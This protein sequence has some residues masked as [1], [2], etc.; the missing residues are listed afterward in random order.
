MPDSCAPCPPAPPHSHIACTCAGPSTR[1]GPSGSSRG[2]RT[3]VAA[4]VRGTS[5][6]AL[7]ALF[8]RSLC[9][10]GIG[11]PQRQQQQQH[12]VGSCQIFD[13]QVFVAWMPSRAAVVAIL[14]RLVAR[15]V[16][17]RIGRCG[18]LV[19]PLMTGNRIE[20]MGG[21]NCSDAA[22]SA[23]RRLV[24][25]EK[26]EIGYCRSVRGV[27]CRYSTVYPKICIIGVHKGSC[28]QERVR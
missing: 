23:E 15:F 18:G 22:S 26:G 21:K 12:K 6:L 14:S 25:E 13:W 4:G 9:T 8:K 24:E 27:N 20:K 28:E 1:T 3:E 16:E 11:P 7:S 17:A 10:C 2:G 5:L 19:H